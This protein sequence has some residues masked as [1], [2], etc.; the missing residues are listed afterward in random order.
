[1]SEF[2]FNTALQMEQRID[3]AEADAIT[4]RW[5]FGKW[6]LTHVPEGGKKLPTGFITNLAEATGKSQRELSYRREFAERCPDYDAFCTVVQN[7]RSWTEIRERAL[8]RRTDT[9]GDARGEVARQARP[10]YLDERGEDA[11]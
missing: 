9:S 2:D 7:H 5:E 11:A 3:A 1:M 8:G 4:E 6:M 10:A